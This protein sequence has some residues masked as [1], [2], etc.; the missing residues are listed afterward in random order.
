MDY[1]SRLATLRH[2]FD[3]LTKKLQSE[4]PD[5]DTTKLEE[6]Q[7]HLQQIQLEIDRIS[8]MRSYKK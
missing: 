6:S 3:V 7:F 1:E 5:A 2:L 4:D 8:K